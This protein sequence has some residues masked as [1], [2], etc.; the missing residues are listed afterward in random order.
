[1]GIRFRK[2]R[3]ALSC[4]SAV[5]CVALAL[6]W[7]RS[8]WRYDALLSG[9]GEDFCGVL[10]VQGKLIPVLHY[11]A[12]LGTWEFTSAKIGPKQ[13]VP[14]WPLLSWAA[15]P[16]YVWV[17]IP[18]WLLAISFAF[19]ARTSWRARFSLRSLLLVT[20]ALAIVLGLAVNGR[21]N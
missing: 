13:P 18:H 7:I 19:T 2:L 15:G 20:T 11:H 8:Y 12:K 10:S 16:S 3:I 9:D 14:P 4:A 1:M 6:L 5:I 17:A 21:Q